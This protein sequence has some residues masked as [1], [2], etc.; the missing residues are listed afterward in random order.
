MNINELIY[1]FINSKDIAE[2]LRNICYQFSTPEAAFLVYCSHK[3][4]LNDKIK[5]WGRITDEMPDC[6]MAERTNMA[7]ISSVHEFLKE[8]I[9]LQKEHLNYFYK[10][11]GAVFFY[12]VR[13]AADAHSKFG[14]PFSSFPKCMEAIKN[15]LEDMKGCQATQI[16]IKKIPLDNRE[17]E[18]NK[19]VCIVEY[20]GDMQIVNLTR[21]AL[22]KEMFDID[23]AFEGMWFRIP[24]PFKKGDIVIGQAQRSYLPEYDV[25]FVLSDD[26]WG[27]GYINEHPKDKKRRER[28]INRLL[29]N[30]DISDMTYSGYWID[31]DGFYCE[32]GYDYLS[33]EYYREPLTDEYRF[34]NVL[35]MYLK[36]A[37]S[38]EFLIRAKDVIFGE[39]KTKERKRYLNQLDEIIKAVGVET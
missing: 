36:N 24:T 20:N 6:S 9:S 14:R 37:C 38:L 8:Y 16:I 39:K 30:G 31:E 3:H 10:N 4:T 21:Y 2:Y 7:F 35:S 1:N 23:S 15:E 22:P 26:I 28:L 32:N 13:Y 29:K 33:L 5:A 12:G 27:E 19:G 17:D 11:D 34:L 18:K 25:P